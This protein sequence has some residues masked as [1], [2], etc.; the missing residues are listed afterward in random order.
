MYAVD[1]ER[2]LGVVTIQPGFHS[3]RQRILRGT[4]TI[5]RFV[6]G[7]AQLSVTDQEGKEQAYSFPSS[8][9]VHNNDVEVKV[10]E[11][12]EW[13]SLGPDPLVYHEIC[14]PPYEDGRF[15]N[16]PQ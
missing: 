2:D 13:N 14:E 11:I 3:P 9:E 15:E 10:G 16:L 6:S 5:Q 7:T 4:K 12:M 1:E 8:N